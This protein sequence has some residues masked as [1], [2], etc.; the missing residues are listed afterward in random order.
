[1]APIVSDVEISRPPDEIYPYVTDPTRFSEWQDDVVTVRLA[2]GPPA[3]VGSQFTTV[4]R[5]GGTE[6]TMTQQITRID[7]PT[8]WAARGVDGPIRP[9]ATITIEPL[10]GARSRV[11]FTLDFEGHGIGV[12]LV[13][14]VR[15]MAAKGAPLS[16]RNLKQRLEGL[17]HD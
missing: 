14:M 4:R 15:R 5:I 7:P 17:P 10:E 16:Y 3:Q 12:P 13:P 8:S 9:S 11:T 6:R 2:E 1:M